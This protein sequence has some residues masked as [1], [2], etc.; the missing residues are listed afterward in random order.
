MKLF[1]LSFASLLMIEGA[2]ALSTPKLSTAT[3]AVPS[4][5]VVE[6]RLPYDEDFD[7]FPSVYEEATDMLDASSLIY[8]I[9]TLRKRALDQIGE[10]GGDRLEFYNS[11]MAE[12]AK[13]L[14]IAD[15]PIRQKSVNGKDD[16]G[17]FFGSLWSMFKGRDKP[18]KERIKDPKAVLRSSLT[19]NEILQ[20]ISENKSVLK[21]EVDQNVNDAL[22]RISERGSS[23]VNEDDMDTVE[24]F[25]D[26]YQDR[27]LV[28]AITVSRS[29]KRVTVTF[30]GSSTT[31]DWIQNLQAKTTTLP[32]ELKEDPKDP[33]EYSIHSGFLNYLETGG[34]SKDITGKR[35]TVF[36]DV[37]GK[38]VTRDYHINKIAQ[39]LLLKNPGFKLYVTGHSLGGALATLFTFRYAAIRKKKGDRSRL[40]KTTTCVSIASPFWADESV[41]FAFEKLEKEGYIRH[42]RIS[43][44][45]DAVPTL[46]FVSLDY[47]T[48]AMKHVG[49]NMKLYDGGKVSFS[50]PKSNNALGRVAGNSLITNINWSAPWKV[51]DYHET[52]LYFNRLK[53]ANTAGVLDGTNLN[54]LYVRKGPL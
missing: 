30:R 10:D 32:N 41:R 1:H 5:A 14:G 35:A 13:R 52:S 25:L 48:R 44:N 49:M 3:T 42:L 38:K 4:R 20:F 46:P 8:A 24:Y 16:D 27:E 9:T 2:L 21:E 22:E 7:Q 34:Y 45:N 29:E 17:G 12:N 31:K 33:E 47:P 40:P 37:N 11:V 18:K 36:V 39:R 51:L 23:M 19:A 43:N 26:E 54:D 50:Y 28:C 6:H 15:Y 53:I